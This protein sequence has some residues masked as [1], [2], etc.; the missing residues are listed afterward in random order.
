MKSQKQ[1]EELI[2]VARAA[3][4]LRCNYGA[5]RDLALRGALVLVWQGSRM[6]VTRASLNQLKASLSQDRSP[7]IAGR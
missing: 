4:E 5:A 6:F 3:G 2:A 7:A 1:E